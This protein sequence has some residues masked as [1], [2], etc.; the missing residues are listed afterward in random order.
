MNDKPPHRTILDKFGSEDEIV[1]LD[2]DYTKQDFYILIAAALGAIVLY[3]VASW[4]AGSVLPP[5]WRAGI[6]FI[7]RTTGVDVPYYGVHP[8]LPGV[9]GVVFGLATLVVALVLIAI[10]P[11]HLTPQAWL[12]D[13][14]RHKRRENTMTALGKTA[15]R[16]TD[17]LSQLSR[18]VPETDAA[19]RTDGALLGAVRVEPANMALAT[20]AEWNAA[21]DELGSAL[22]SLTFAFQLHSTARP[23]DPDDIT[24]AYASRLDDRDVRENPALSH[25]VDVY[26]RKLPEEFAARGTS[27]RAY[28]I[29]VPVRVTDVQLGDRGAASRLAKVPKVGG[30]IETILGSRSDMTDAE[31]HAEQVRELRSRLDDVADA[32]NGIADARAEPATGDDLATLVEEYWLGKRTNYPGNAAEPRTRSL[33]VVVPGDA[34]DRA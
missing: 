6:Q 28:H 2:T 4:A 9:F 10:A 27:V 8:A 12:A 31:I 11:E 23:V 29:L 5:L 13:I 32:V 16:R 25:I 15:D 18:F 14:Y 3:E 1:G 33:P 24:A 7:Y 21:A 34:E 22:N 17:S 26:D 30:V 19:E 20:D